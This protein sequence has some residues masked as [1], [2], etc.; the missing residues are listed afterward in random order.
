[1]GH[2]KNV[3]QVKCACI[4][5]IIFQTVILISVVKDGMHFSSLANL[6]GQSF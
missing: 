6:K 2:H 1:M 5:Y 3:S 4:A